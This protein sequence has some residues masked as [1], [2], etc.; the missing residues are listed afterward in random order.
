MRRS[1]ARNIRIAF[2]AGK[3]SHFGG[4]YLLHQFFQ[5]LQIRTYLSRRLAYSQKNNRYSTTEFLLALIYPMILGLEKIEVS[6]LLKTNGVFQYL[7]G[8]PN[9]PDPT[10]LRRFLLRSP[11]ELMPLLWKAH[12]NLRKNFIAQPSNLPS[13][14]IDFDSTA[15]TLYGHQDG[16]VKGYNPGHIGKKS[17]HPL[18]V[19]EAH[20]RDAL[21]GF[22]RYG[23]AHTAEGVIPLF[24][25]AVSLLPHTRNLRSRADAGFYEKTFVKEMDKRNIGFAV[26]AKM[27]APVKRRLSCL[28]YHKINSVFSTSEFSYQPHQWDKEY[29]FVVLRRK[30]EQEPEK[31]LT[32]F[33]L[34]Q[35]AYSVI[36]TNLSL[37]PHG[38]FAFYK[39]RA[40]LERIIRILKNDFPFGGAPTKNFAANALYAELSLLAYNLITWFKRL[41][42]PD[43]WQSFTLPKLRHQLFMMPG[44]LVHTGNV[45]TLKFPKNSPNENV[46]NFAINKIKK[47]G[48]LA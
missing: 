11:S 36:V 33:T 3:L 18:V 7:T 45:P 27:T 8:L 46:F 40:G 16:V 28:R 34:D 5:K 20:L 21:G 26:V 32:L 35:Y 2:T 24:R 25:E 6:A 12:N 19:A 22:L 39:N 14:C 37:T 43:D 38:I 41:C 44:E 47:L 42:L 9:F 17:Y 10:T 29:R 4:I 48:P 13:Y 23:N 30:I 15:N 31:E 1:G